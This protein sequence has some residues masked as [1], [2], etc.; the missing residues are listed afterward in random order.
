MRTGRRESYRSTCRR[1]GARCGGGS[2]PRAAGILAPRR[3]K[4]RKKRRKNRGGDITP[5]RLRR[6]LFFVAPATPAGTP[7]RRQ[8]GETVQ[9]LPGRP[10]CGLP[11]APKLPR[12]RR[13]RPVEPSRTGCAGAAGGRASAQ[14]HR[15]RVLVAN[16]VSAWPF[17]SPWVRKGRTTKNRRPDR[18]VVCNITDSQL[19]TA[20]YCAAL[21]GIAR[22]C[23]AKNIAP[24]PVSAHRPPF[25][26]GLTTSAVSRKMNPC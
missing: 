2:P 10:G 18:R 6:S 4:R 5:M 17:G 8:P 22:Y 11:G 19:T 23:A 20:H 13:V 24:E 12:P 14:A 26:V 16:Q 9:A 3:K 15:W 25:S 21:R 7:S 1:R